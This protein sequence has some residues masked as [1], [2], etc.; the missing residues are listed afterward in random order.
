MPQL[1][2]PE[3][4][5]RDYGV[6]EGGGNRCEVGHADI[7]L[8]IE[9]YGGKD[10]DGHG[11]GED[12]EAQFTGATLERV[13]EDAQP[14]RVAREL[15]DTEHAEDA[16]RHK[17]PADVVVVRDAQADVVRH[18]GHH[19]DDAHHTANELAAVRS[20]EQTEQVLGREDH[21]AGRVQAEEDDLVAFAAGQGASTTWSDAARNRLHNVGHNADCDEKSSD[22]IEDLEERR[23]MNEDELKK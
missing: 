4:R 2:S 21:H 22:I 23:T 7:L 18:D 19:V 10:N 12:E 9:H 3:S 14:L 8:G 11:Q 16:Q 1:N 6:P 5:H 13:A 15:K 20:R 17:G